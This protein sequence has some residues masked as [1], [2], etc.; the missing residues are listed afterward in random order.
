[1]E[2]YNPSSSS[3]E[4]GDPWFCIH[5]HPKHEHIASANLRALLGVETWNPRIAFTRSTRRGIAM[6]TESVFPGYFFARFDLDTALDS[7]R[8]TAGV[9]NVVHFGAL[10]PR[11]PDSTIEHLKTCFA[12]AD[13]MPVEEDLVPGQKTLITEGTFCGIEVVVLRT[14]PGR[15]RVQ[16]LLDMLGTVATAELDVQTISTQRL[17]PRSIVATLPVAA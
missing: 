1:M 12:G 10:Y 4:S 7:V 2:P 15:R 16:V 13:V 8:Y 6:V 17:Y 9:S 5:S 11:I 14:L 3:M